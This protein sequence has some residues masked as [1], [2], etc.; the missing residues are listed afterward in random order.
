VFTSMALPK[1][2]A[3]HWGG[4]AATAYRQL[5]AD[6]LS[7]AIDASSLPPNSEVGRIERIGNRSSNNVRK[8]RVMA[9]TTVELTTSVPVWTAAS[10]PQ[11]L[12]V[13]ARSCAG[14]TGQP[15][16][17][18]APRSVAVTVATVA[19]KPPRCGCTDADGVGGAT[20]AGLSVGDADAD[21]GA[22]DVTVTEVALWA[23]VEI[24]AGDSESGCVAERLAGELGDDS[25]DAVELT[26][27]AFLWMHPLAAASTVAAARAAL[28][29][30]LPRQ[31]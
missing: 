8:T 14:P 13:R 29:R 1:A 20:A 5:N 26:E 19:V 23:G 22:A 31:S 18:L 12:S 24:G 10:K 17:Q 3:D 25:A 30:R 16:C 15:G 21:D 9:G 6:V 27:A 2:C 4:P 7:T 28:T 11:K